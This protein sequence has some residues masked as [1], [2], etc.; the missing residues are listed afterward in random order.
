MILLSLHSP[1]I[2]APKNFGLR[3]PPLAVMKSLLLVG[4]VIQSLANGVSSFKED[5]LKCMNSFL[6]KN[7]QN[8]DNFV[9]DVRQ[10]PPR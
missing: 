7:K 1:C 4:K 6:E 8:I 10:W 3:D 5:H 9:H 2:A